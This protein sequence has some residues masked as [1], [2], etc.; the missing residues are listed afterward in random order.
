MG[1]MDQ[2]YGLKWIKY[3]VDWIKLK[4]KCIK[5]TLKGDK[6][7]AKNEIKIRVK[8]DTNEGKMGYK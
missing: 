5:M 3:R 2:K 1:F 6:I 7:R 4:V 8:L